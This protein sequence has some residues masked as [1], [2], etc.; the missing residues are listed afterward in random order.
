MWVRE[1]R[2]SV[3]GSEGRSVSW[4]GVREKG[5][6]GSDLFTFLRGVFSPC[7]LILCLKRGL[8]KI[9]ASETVHWVEETRTKE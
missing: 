6:S 7:F 4:D 8:R 1:G 2:I 3:T 5:V 9:D